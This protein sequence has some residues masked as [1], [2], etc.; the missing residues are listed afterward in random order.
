[1][2]ETE[3]SVGSITFWLFEFIKFFIVEYW[4]EI[5]EDLSKMFIAIYLQFIRECES[6]SI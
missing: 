2:R 1:M 5:W 6:F 4:E 3:T